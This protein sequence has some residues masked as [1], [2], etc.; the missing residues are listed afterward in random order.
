MAE[1]L[2]PE[3]GVRMDDDV[4]NSWTAIVFAIVSLII[5]WMFLKPTPNN[6][7]NTVNTTR[8]S[9]T[10]AMHQQHP[11]A[12]AAARRQQ[13]LAERRPPAGG[14]AANHMSESALAVLSEC[15]SKPSF[16]KTDLEKIGIGGYNALIDGLVAFSHTQASSSLSSGGTS[17]MDRTERARVLSRL[18][19]TASA[20]TGT[21]VPPP[22]KGSTIVVALSPLE[23]SLM[24]SSDK[25]KKQLSH[26]L[27]ILGSYYTLIVVGTIS[28]TNA[29]AS[30][31]TTTTTAAMMKEQEKN[32]KQ[33]Q[34][35]LFSSGELTESILPKH[36]ILMA[37]SKIGRIALVRQLARVELVVDYE[38]EVQKE[39]GRFGYKV[40]VIPKL[41]GLLDD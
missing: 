35:I 14:A 38:D 13:P 31:S 15:Q 3:E 7:D 29:N 4:S 34:D 20:S 5:Y 2:S 24:A 36:R 27:S 40:T 19:T 9:R 10:Q 22:G 30:T 33:M 32:Q 21:V 37:S 39:L 11:P 1:P 8:S 28:N 25:Q 17:A 12:A 26:I 6:D 18:L 16:V 23:T 41:S